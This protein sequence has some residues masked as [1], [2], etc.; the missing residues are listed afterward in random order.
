MRTK[1]YGLPVGLFAGLAVISA[2]CTVSVF[3][4]AKPEEKKA[5][6]SA[7]AERSKALNE[8]DFSWKRAK[9]WS[10]DYI[11]AMPEEGI[12]FKPTPEIR[13][14]A[15]QMLH[16]AFWNYGL[17]EWV[18]GKPN[19]FG[20]E[21]KNLETKS[22]YKTKAALRKV[23]EQSYDFV[24]DGMSGLDNARLLEEVSFFNTKMTRL[25]VL[26]I[27]LDHQT[28]HRGQTTIYLRL[29][30]VTPPPEP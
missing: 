18:A 8:L 11:D 19:P 6:A 1:F 24:M 23:V 21:Q 30:G 9:K 27:A 3:A 20:K 17:A 12:N 14:F 25:N 26:A 15:E 13:S 10:L 22:E 4:Q 2:L 28:H 16:L 7:T 5:A 29:K